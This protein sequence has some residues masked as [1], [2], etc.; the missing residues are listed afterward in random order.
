MKPQCVPVTVDVSLLIV[1]IG[2]ELHPYRLCSIAISNARISFIC[3]RFTVRRSPTQI[4]HLLPVLPM[5]EL[6]LPQESRLPPPAI[7]P[8]HRASI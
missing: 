8:N 1:G 3:S 5:H 4:R 7:Y 2:E 6:H